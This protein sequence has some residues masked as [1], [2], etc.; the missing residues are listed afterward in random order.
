[1]GEGGFIRQSSFNKQKTV[2]LI[3]VELED[4]DGV[5]VFPRVLVA[6]L[7]TKSQFWAHLG[8]NAE[9]NHTGVTY[10]QLVKA[11]QTIK[12]QAEFSMRTFLSPTHGYGDP[13]LEIPSTA[14]NQSF[15]IWRPQ[16]LR[17]WNSPLTKT[18]KLIDA[19]I[20]NIKKRRIFWLVLDSQGGS[21]VSTE[22]CYW[23]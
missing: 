5:P 4:A 21:G 12:L 17:I 1:M 16:V 20:E 3:Q 19:D 14:I 2:E 6:D 11:G 7:N 13:H 8:L 9:R 15:R 10:G 18:E 22:C 23:S